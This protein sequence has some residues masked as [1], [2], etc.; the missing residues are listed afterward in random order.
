MSDAATTSVPLVNRKRVLKQRPVGLLTDGDLA[1][2][3]E[4]L[5]DC[6]E[7]EA[8]IEVLYLG[9]DA[10]VRTWLNRGEGY[11]PAV[12]IGEVVRCSG[13]GRVIQSRCETI[14]VG[15]L[16]YGL[17]GWQTHAIVRDDLF[18]TRLPPDADVIPMMSIYGATGAT[19]LFGLTEIGQAK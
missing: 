19:A 13:I 8:L 6:A 18:T 16:A 17:P 11:L 10:T 9:M 4:P 7:G 12:E 2:E 15:D 3:E 5:P 1:W 14:A